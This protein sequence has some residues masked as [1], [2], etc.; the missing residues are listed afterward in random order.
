MKKFY[1]LYFFL[2]AI[3]PICLILL[4]KDFFNYGQSICLSIFLFNKECYACGLTK[5]IMHFLHLDVLKA[6]QFNKLS[7]VVFP[8]L[9][10]SYYKEIRRIFNKIQ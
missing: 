6:Y 8:F 3:I 5:A 9:C 2:L 10:F 7:I 1:Y 4:P